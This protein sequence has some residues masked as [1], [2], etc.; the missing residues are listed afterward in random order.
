MPSG[1]YWSKR[2]DEILIRRMDLLKG[3]FEKRARQIL[4]EGLLP[5]RAV[6]GA[7]SRY[8]KLLSKRRDRVAAKLSV[9]DRRLAQFG[10]MPWSKAEDGILFDAMKG[11]GPISA[12]KLVKGLISSNALPKR[13]N[14]AMSLR[15]RHLRREA[16]E[17]MKLGPRAVG[18]P[19]L[20]EDISDES[21]PDC[22][23][24]YCAE[25]D[26]CN[27]CDSAED[28]GSETPRDYEEDEGHGDL[29][30]VVDDESVIFRPMEDV[31][32]VLD[33]P[34]YA[35]RRVVVYTMDTEGHPCRKTAIETIGMYAAIPSQSEVEQDFETSE[36]GDGEYLL[37]D[38]QKHKLVK[39]YT[40][41]LRSPTKSRV[42]NNDKR[43]LIKV[44]LLLDKARDNREA[45]HRL[46]PRALKAAEGVYAD[47]DAARKELGKMATLIKT[48]EVQLEKTAMAV[49]M[50]E[51][52]HKKKMSEEADNLAAEMEEN[53]AALEREKLVDR[54]LKRR[55]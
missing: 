11:A 20:H 36:Y 30:P 46:F 32:E 26:E 22:F 50:V 33:L 37:V 41:K 19:M 48:L 29:A 18:E 31:G 25:D 38:V 4:R 15:I 24:N 21:H 49:K 6:G 17:R 13:T 1:K 7:V 51:A 9:S 2:E 14:E 40:I 53:E 10:R 5:G 44:M 52:L 55:D 12:A 54:E 39:R 3:D 28:C 23:G 8:Y 47:I 42:L 16:G 27:K 34:K 45:W 43:P 35:M